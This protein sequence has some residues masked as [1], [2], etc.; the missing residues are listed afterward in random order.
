MT[1]DKWSGRVVFVFTKHGEGTEADSNPFN[2]MKKLPFRSGW[3]PFA[4]S[5][6]FSAMS[7]KLLIYNS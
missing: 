3:E 6:E 7:N 5:R 4:T 2:A 1:G